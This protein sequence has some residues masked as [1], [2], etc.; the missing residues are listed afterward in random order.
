MARSVDG[1]VLYKAAADSDGEDDFGPRAVLAVDGEPLDDGSPPC[2]GLEY[3]RRVRKEASAI[4]DV[5]T[6]SID[7]SKLR[8]ADTRSTKRLSTPSSPSLPP[9][10]PPPPL[11]VQPHPS[12]QLRLLS[13]FGR[14][15]IRLQACAREVSAR[16]TSADEPV[17][18]LPAHDDTAGWTRYVGGSK[19]GGC[20][21]ALSLAYRLDHQRAVSVVQLASAQ[22]P[23]AVRGVRIGGHARPRA[24]SLWIFA[25]MARMERELDAHNAAMV[26]ELLKSCWQLRAEIAEE[27]GAERRTPEGDA[28]AGGEAAR[29]VQTSAL[30][31]CE[32]AAAADI[33]R[34]DG[35]RA[36]EAGVGGE[37]ALVA[38]SLNMLITLAGG[39]FGQAAEAE[40]LT[41]SGRG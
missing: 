6:A 18:P 3:L 32:V 34:G 23:D 31:A 39:F 24:L 14:L 7:P 35:A 28:G 9:P 36:T 22:L 33:G 4:P 21:P 15:R 29:D 13:D 20:E 25:G 27:A 1:A 37:P 30:R 19:G 2:D 41:R 11:A 26:R 12:W 17:S 10:L 16:A 5:V 8:A 38:A 40:W